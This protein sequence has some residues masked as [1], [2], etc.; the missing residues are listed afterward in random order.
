MGQAM[1]DQ[2]NSK[3]VIREIGR[4]RKSRGL[5][6]TE[7]ATSTSRKLDTKSSRK[8]YCQGHECCIRLELGHY[9]EILTRKGTSRKKSL[10]T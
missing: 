4:L 10:I 1:D 5:W 6:R 3:G 7:V 2:T 9:G 8:G